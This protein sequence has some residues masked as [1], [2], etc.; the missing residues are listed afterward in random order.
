MNLSILPKDL[1]KPKD[2]G[3]SNHL[4]NKQ[5]F[6]GQDRLDFLEDFVDKNL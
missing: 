4:T 3:A 5:I 6:W 1:P 2:D